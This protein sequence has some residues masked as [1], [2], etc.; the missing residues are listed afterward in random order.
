MQM[1]RRTALR[2]GAA[3]LAT[4]GLPALARAAEA[5]VATTYPGS[6][7]EAF[8]AVVGPAFTKATG[9]NVNFTPL[10]AIDQVADDIEGT[11][12]VGT[13]VPADPCLGEAR[14]QRFKYAGSALE[15]GNAVLKI[16]GHDALRVDWTD[17]TRGPTRPRSPPATTAASTSRSRCCRP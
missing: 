5:V 8:K 10:L 9:A 7:D 12:G 1:S 15:N 13:F 2:L 11:P 17:E 14:Q 16:E 3:S 6:F 4:A